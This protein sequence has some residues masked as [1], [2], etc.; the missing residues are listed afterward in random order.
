MYK[1]AS[2][3]GAA[4]MLAACAGGGSNYEFQAAAV[5]EPE[6]RI[7]FVQ[8]NGIRDYHA[9]S[10]RLL[11]VQSRDRNWYQVDLFAPCTGLEFAMG[12]RFRPSDGAG[13]FDRFSSIDM[14]GQS[15]KVR[16][17]KRVAPPM[18]GQD[19]AGYANRYERDRY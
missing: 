17:V 16:S 15:C 19:G 10:D 12:V 14:R 3:A 18:R 13:T 2:I 5:G 6:A 11:Y 7:N 8:Y 4:L 9:V 1:I